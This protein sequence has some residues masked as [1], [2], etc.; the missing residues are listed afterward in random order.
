MRRRD[1]APIGPWIIGILG[2]VPFF[3]TL[4]GSML[5]T[6]PLD[7]V[8][9]TLFFAYAGV[10]LSFLG[11]ARWGF[12]IG[13]RPEAP[14]FFTLSFSVMPSLVGAIAMLSQYIA[15]LIG[16]ALLAGGFMLM[17]LWDFVS[18]GGSTRRWPL[19]YQPLRTILTLG[20]LAA[21]GA[22]AWLTLPN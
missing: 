4:A 1:I 16:L 12:E 8:S 15:P 9:T 18:S 5:A 17:W 7:G 11:G 10:I 3:G 19:W 22:K 21:L 14:D 6:A 13:A 20:A 2:L